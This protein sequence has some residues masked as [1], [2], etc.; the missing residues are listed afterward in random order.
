MKVLDK[1]LLRERETKIRTITLWG[2]LVN[3]FLMAMKIF[4]GILIKSSALIAD[5]FHSL[6]DLATD[7]VV[8][9]GARLSNRPPDEAHPYGHK[10]FE[11]LATQIV[12][13][14]LLG[15]GFGGVHLLAGL[16]RFFLKKK[17]PYVSESVE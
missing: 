8:L 6:S 5:G 2:V 1:N 7:F 13:L 17:M 4:S 3:I 12:G 15:V 11:T 10:R 16:G 9:A 14:I